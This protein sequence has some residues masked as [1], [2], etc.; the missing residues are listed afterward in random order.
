MTTGEKHKNHNTY[1][2]PGLFRG[3]RVLEVIA[4]FEKAMTVSEIGR[5]IGVSRSSAFRLI[6]TLN[7]MGFIASGD[8]GRTY[9]LGARVL[10]LGFSFLASQDFIQTARPELVALRDETG[11]SSHLA[12]LEQNDVLFLDCIQSTS[13]FLSNVNVGRRVPAYATPL[14]WLLLSELSAR[15]LVKKYESVNLVQLTN[16]TP[17]TIE[18]ILSNVSKAGARGIVVSHGIVAKGGCS[19]CAPIYD[20]TGKIVAA[21]DISGPESIFDGIDIEATLVPK[22]KFASQ[23]ISRK[24][25]YMGY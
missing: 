2:V 21:L 6:Y 10:N 22:V 23:N 20:K 4:E 11:I 25:G 7:D 17:R 18:D 19:I 8:E 15:D 14:G 5:A 12:I 3:L 24:L 1:F 9:Q 13:G 16:K